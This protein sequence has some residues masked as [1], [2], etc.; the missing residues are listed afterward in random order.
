VSPI[1]TGRGDPLPH[2]TPSPAFGL[3]SPQ[4]FSRGYALDN[5]EIGDVPA[6]FYVG[7]RGTGVFSTKFGEDMV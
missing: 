7:F 6:I 4:L 2:P 5:S 1:T 3:G